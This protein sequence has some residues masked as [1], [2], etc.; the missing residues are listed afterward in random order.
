MSRATTP[1]WRGWPTRSPSSRPSAEC[2]AFRPGTAC[3]TTAF[4][5]IPAIVSERIATLARLLRPAGGPRIV[6]TT[7]NALVQRVPPRGDVSRLQPFAEAGRPCS[8]RCS[9]PSSR[10]MA[11]AA[12]GTVMEPGEFAMRG[13]IIDL[14]P[15]GEP[16]PSGSTCSATA[17]RACARFD[18]TTQ[19]S[20]ESGERLDLASGVR[21]A[22]RP[23][24]RRALPHRLARAVRP[25]GGG[26]PALPLDLRPAAGIRAWSIGCRCSMTPWKRCSTTC[27]APP[28]ASTIRRR[29]CWR[30]G[31]R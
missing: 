3:P 16:E 22:A 8:P 24:E 18:P 31:W 2:C 4:R 17:S 30:P 5:P 29:R 15:A 12:R 9:R 10:R 6:L 20:G 27:P 28:S 25:G 23:R 11:T 19:R 13:G 21:G 14:F 7:V 26:R 1:A